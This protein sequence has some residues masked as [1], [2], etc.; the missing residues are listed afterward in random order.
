LV[1]VSLLTETVVLKYP[2]GMLSLDEARQ[3]DPRLKTLSDDE[4]K[5]AIERL[6]VL[7]EIAFRM[8]MDE[9]GRFDDFPEGSLHHNPQGSTMEP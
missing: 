8:W 4:L 1:T 5:D 9:M 6:Q 3:L 2:N 7:A